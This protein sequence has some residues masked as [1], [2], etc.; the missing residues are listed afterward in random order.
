MLRKAASE[1]RRQA[2]KWKIS[3]GAEL[4]HF[5]IVVKLLKVNAKDRD[6]L[7]ILV[8]ALSFTRNKKI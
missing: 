2:L 3:L 5:K 6:R 1:L 7:R 4:V 8:G